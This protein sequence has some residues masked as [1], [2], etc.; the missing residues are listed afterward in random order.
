MLLLWEALG[1]SVGQ[2]ENVVLGVPEPLPDIEPAMSNAFRETV[3]LLRGRGL[4]VEPVPI[5][6]M[7]DK[8]AEETRVVEFYEGARFHEQRFKQYGARLLDLAELVRDGLQISDQRYGE[9][10]RFISQSKEQLAER[11][12]GTPVILVPAAT[13][14]APRGLASTGD[15]RMNSPWSALGT[16]AISVPMPVSKGLPLGIQLTAAHGQ[17][18]RVLRTAVQLARLFSS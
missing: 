12:Q 6:P 11:Y 10:L 3:S 9:A 16:P 14:A 7:L 4:A 8:L 13:G 2:D 18:A 5:T 15:G 17:D 1:E